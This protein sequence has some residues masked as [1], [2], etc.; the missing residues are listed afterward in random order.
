MRSNHCLS[1]IGLERRGAVIEAIGPEVTGFAVGD[2]RCLCRHAGR[3][4]CASPHRAGRA[5]HRAPP[6]A[7]TE[8]TAA[9]MMIRGHDRADGCWSTPTA[10][11][12]ETPILVHAAAGGGRPDHVPVGEASRRHRDRHP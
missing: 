3:L 10:S 6:P 7:S 8:R 5:A 2:R 11:S 1:G 4:V 12:R 9:S